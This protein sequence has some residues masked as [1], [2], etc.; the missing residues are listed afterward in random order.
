[1]NLTNT[2]N[3]FPNRSRSV[4]VPDI[5]LV[6]SINNPPYDTNITWTLN[7]VQLPETSSSLV[8]TQPGTY[9]GSAAPAFCP[10]QTE[11][12]LPITVKINNECNLEVPGHGRKIA[13]YPNPADNEITVFS[14]SP[15]DRYDIVDLTGKNI[16]NGHLS[17]EN[18]IVIADIAAGLY[19]LRLRQN[20][21][22]FNHKI[23]IR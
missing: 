20:A 16:Q 10:D 9:Q 23:I 22:I 8:V 1:M 13:I 15:V 11:S 4:Y 3:I 2:R 6:C 17:A 21:Q 14:L 19:F 12:T 7:G 5:P 18:T